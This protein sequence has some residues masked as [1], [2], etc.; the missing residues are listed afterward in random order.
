MEEEKINIVKPAKYSTYLANLLAISSITGNLYMNNDILFP[1][2]KPIRN[3]PQFMR[4]KDQNRNELCN[5]GSG[6]K[7]KKCCGK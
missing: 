1:K 7:Y 2:N 3:V 6:S 4:K 5:C